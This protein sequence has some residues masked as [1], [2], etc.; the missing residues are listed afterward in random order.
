MFLNFADDLDPRECAQNYLHFTSRVRSDVE[1]SLVIQDISTAK[2]IKPWRSQWPQYHSPS[3]ILAKADTPL[4]L[5]YGHCVSA[6][7]AV[8]ALA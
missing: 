4:V 2:V 1:A 7:T 6:R 5:Q 8:H 3:A